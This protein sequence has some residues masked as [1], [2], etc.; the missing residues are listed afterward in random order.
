ME[1]AS[2]LRGRFAWLAVAALFACYGWL[3]LQGLGE[4]GF[5]GPD[6]PRYA[7]I[8]RQMQQSG[9]WIT[10]KLWTEAGVQPPSIE[11]WYEKPPLLYWLAG[12][13]Y[14][15]GLSPERAARVPVTCLALVFLLLYWLALKTLEDAGTAT[16]ASLVMST[17]AGWLAFSQVA[18]T[19][20]PLAVTFSGAILAAV[21]R[22]NGGGIWLTGAAGVC[23]GLALLAK[24]LVAGVLILPVLWFARTRWKE[25]LAVFAVAVL[26]AG[27]W[28]VA[29]ISRHGMAFIDEFFLRHHFSRFS[30]N[31]LQH[32]Q[33]WWFYVV[34]LLG[35]LFP[36]TSLVAGL[37]PSLWKAPHRRI[38]ATVFLFGFVFFSA[39]T[40]KLPGYLLPLWP[41]LCLLAAVGLRAAS[42]KHRS[43]TVAGL[44]LSLIPLVASVLPQALLVGVRRAEWG[45]LPWEYVAMALPFAALARWL[46]LRGKLT[47]AVTVVAVGAGLGVRFVQLSAYPV[48]DEIVSTRRLAARVRPMHK[49]ICIEQMHRATRYGLNFYL[50]QPL[51]ECA[52]TPEATVHLT[53]S[54]TGLYQLEP[55]PGRKPAG[56]PE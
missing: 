52:V 16:I 33:P 51:P 54:P 34:V 44:L 10:P 27:P 43:L 21:L 6:E 47:A 36:W 26:V 22:L 9:D 28:Y 48:L 30:S 19:D 32:V 35:G 38:F 39:S 20:I 3:A 1:P 53:Q 11:P 56:A 15:L 23:F 37:R 50:G 31:E 29:M 24:G 45:A 5:L 46:A 18:V 42:D 2:G 41:S 4:V 55:L 7:F 8:A 49:E 12:A 13:G 25:M 17:S 40:N 14:A